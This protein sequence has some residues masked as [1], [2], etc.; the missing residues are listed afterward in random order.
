MDVKEK[1][2]KCLEHH[3][4]VVAAYLFGSASENAPVRNDLDILVL[5]RDGVDRFEAHINLKCSLA[6]A[7]GIPERRIDLL[8]FDLS[9]A[10]PHVLVRAVNSGVLIKN[11]DPRFLSERIGELSRYFLENE[12]VIRRAEILKKERLEAFGG[13]G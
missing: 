5:L 11:L 4:E 9:Q 10:R 8:F 3:P 1:L 7:A 6:E 12:P 13:V 2:K